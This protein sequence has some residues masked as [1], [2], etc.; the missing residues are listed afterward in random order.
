MAETHSPSEFAKLLGHEFDQPE[1]LEAALTHRSFASEQGQS[2]HYERLEFLGDAVLG[3]L[4]SE[5]LFEEFPEVP[6]GR[7]SE[8]KGYIVSEPA[9]AAHARHLDL[10]SALRLGV[11]EERSGGREKAS[12]LSDAMEAVFGAV[13]L[14]AGL[15]GAR[16]LVGPMLQTALEERSSRP[17]GNAKGR[18][19]ELCQGRGW[20]LPQYAHIAQEGPDHEKLFT[21]ECRVRDISM[22]VATGRSK[23]LAEQRAAAAALAVLEAS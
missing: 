3:V 13:Y 22:A 6:E 8:L 18:L 12:I 20:E 23:L 7:L 5:W 10:G 2:E 19:Q 1:L 17:H 4:A 21:V 9:L 16:R 11:G 15:D 14:D